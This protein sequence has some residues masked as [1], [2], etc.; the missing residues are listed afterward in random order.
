M[1]ST[2]EATTCPPKLKERRRK[3]SI[4]TF[5]AVRWIT[6]LCSNDGDR[7]R[8]TGYHGAQLAASSRSTIVTSGGAASQHNISIGMEYARRACR[9]N[10]F[11]DAALSSPQF[12]NDLDIPSA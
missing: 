12:E 9:W 1:A 6:S 5:V 2:S 8:C 3:Q 10:H 11:S 4:L 7:L